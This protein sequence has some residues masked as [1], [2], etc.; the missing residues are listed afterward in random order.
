MKVYSKK[1]LAVILA[2]F[3]MISTSVGSALNVYAANYTT[4]YSNYNEP[5][6]N[7]YAY[8]NGSA[9]VKGSGT[10]TSEIKWMQAALNYCISKKGLNASKL[11]VDG[12]FGPASKKTTTA[13]QK[14]YG[15]TQDG[16]FGPTTIS[17][18]K[19]VLSNNSNSKSNNSN[20][21]SNNSNS[22][23]L[24]V[25]STKVTESNVK[26]E[27]VT[28]E[29]DTSSMDNW[30]NSVKKMENYICTSKKGII[31]ASKIISKKTVSWKIPRTAV[32]QGPGITGYIKQKYSVPYKV[33]YKLHKH[34]KNHG[35]GK[36]WYYSAGNIVSIYTCDCGYIR[37]IMEWTIPLPDISSDNTTKKIIQGLPKIN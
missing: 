10:G 28:V 9:V 5:E 7:D 13:F 27:Y 32:Y 19:N 21:K 29:L 6:S 2:I 16:S 12:S 36:C 30:V 35:F 8:W 15:L 22:K 3:T 25:S 33:Q 34:T 1:I 26:Y 11:D 31:V 23:Q 17:K 20:S 37:E 18:M 4:N 14:K 24:T